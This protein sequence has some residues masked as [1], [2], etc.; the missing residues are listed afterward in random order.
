MKIE[1]RIKKAFNL[2]PIWEL[3]KELVKEGYTENTIVPLLDNEH[4][5]QDGLK[6]KLR[7]YIRDL[8]FKDKTK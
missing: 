2:D 1:N 8:K 7:N 6:L 3:A 5:L 4:C